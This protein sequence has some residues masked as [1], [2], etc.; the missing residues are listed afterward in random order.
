MSGKEIL[1]ISVESDGGAEAV[2]VGDLGVGSWLAIEVV[3]LALLDEKLFH[4]SLTYREV[5]LLRRSRLLGL[6]QGDLEDIVEAVVSQLVDV[7]G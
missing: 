7:A 2:M 1:S 5:L 6:L 3:R 4:F